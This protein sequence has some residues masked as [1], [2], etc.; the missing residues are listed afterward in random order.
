MF[1]KQWKNPWE[2]TG[3]MPE[4]RT[5]QDIV[6]FNLVMTLIMGFVFVVFILILR[7]VLAGK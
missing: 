6:K 3:K 1:G 5:M 7:F 4:N 2:F